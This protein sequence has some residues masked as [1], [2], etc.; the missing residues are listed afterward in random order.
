M[1]LWAQYNWVNYGFFHSHAEILCCHQKGQIRPSRPPPGKKP[2][3]MF[4]GE[5][6]S[7][8][9]TQVVGHCFFSFFLFLSTHVFVHVWEESGRMDS[10]LKSGCL[11]EER[12]GPNRFEPLAIRA[13]PAD[14]GTS[15]PHLSRAGGEW[16][17]GGI[18]S[19]N[20]WGALGG[21]GLL[22]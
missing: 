6:A 7:Y 19:S 5:K 10:I 22:P 21:P 18:Q 11:W 14:R 2:R 15:G 1:T 17:S 4:S 12:C 13:L 8:R 16:P 20:S 9:R 3:H